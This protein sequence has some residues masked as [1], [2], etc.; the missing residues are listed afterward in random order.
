[1]GLSA[2]DHANILARPVCLTFLVVTLLKR[3]NIR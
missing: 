2:F 3:L 1:M